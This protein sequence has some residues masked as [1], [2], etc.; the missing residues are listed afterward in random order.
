MKS[1]TIST[2]LGLHHD[3]L[4]GM[5]CSDR[6]VTPLG[7]LVLS[8]VITD[9]YYNFFCPDIA[10]DLSALGSISDQLHDRGRQPALYVTPLSSVRPD[11]LANFPEHACDSWMLRE[12]TPRTRA[13]ENPDIEIKRVGGERRDE[14]LSTF[15][16]AY[17]TDDAVELYGP[18]DETYLQALSRSFDLTSAKYEKFYLLATVDGTAAGVI[19]LMVAGRY[20][21]AYALGTVADA[22]RHGVGSALMSE[23]ANLAF[24]AG[25]EFVFLQAEAGSS[26]EKYHHKL[27]YR[28]EFHGTCYA[29][30][31]PQ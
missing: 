5:F 7:D 15:S 21:G 29:A 4:L 11:E 22:R 18:P 6:H 28:H 23:C 16:A 2:L 25:A 24:E 3:F 12:T 20:A 19:I 30:P 17:S 27:G 31:A 10:F 1:T 9:P 8:E 13:D 26:A 14:F